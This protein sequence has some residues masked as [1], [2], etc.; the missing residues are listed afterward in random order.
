MIIIASDSEVP[1]IKTAGVA[2]LVGRPMVNNIFNFD[3]GVLTKL[4]FLAV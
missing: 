2:S 4:V 1:D 3:I